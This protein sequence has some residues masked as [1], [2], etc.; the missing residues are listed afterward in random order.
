MFGISRT[1]DGCG[2]GISWLPTMPPTMEMV[3]TRVAATRD[4]EKAIVRVAGDPHQ[5]PHGQPIIERHQIACRQVNAPAR[6]G[7]AQGEFIS[8]AVDVD[9]AFER[10]DFPAAIP[11]RFEAFEPEDPMSDGGVGLPLPCEADWF[12]IHEH[13]P[14]RPSPSGLV[15]DAVESERRAVGVHDLPNAEARGRDSVPHASA[16]RAWEERAVS[17]DR[18]SRGIQ[19]D[20]FHLLSLHPHKQE[21]AGQPNPK[22]AA[23]QDHPRG[24]AWRGDR[25]ARQGRDQR[26]EHRSGGGG[27]GSGLLTARF[28]E[29]DSPATAGS[30]L[31]D[32]SRAGRRGS[33]LRV[34]TKT[35]ERRPFWLYFSRRP[36]G[37]SSGEPSWNPPLDW[38]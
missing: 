22:S 30:V 13:N 25:A 7:A 6:G 16:R 31:R 26:Q 11:P 9:A 12:P 18:L 10:V 15:R 38:K 33:H 19:F 17:G 20:P 8:D 14:N 24:Q 21:M 3:N 36:G 4:P 5:R 34:L 27:R 32:S 1:P 2:R 35:F 29:R 37:R 23:G 28:P